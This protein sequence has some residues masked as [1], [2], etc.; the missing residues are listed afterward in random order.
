M[1]VQ[2]RLSAAEASLPDASSPDLSDGQKPAA[3]SALSRVWSWLGWGLALPG[4]AGVVLVPMD[5]SGQMMAMIAVIAA[6]WVLRT[7]PNDEPGSPLR[8]LVLLLTAIVSLRYIAWRGLFTLNS[9]TLIS[10]ALAVILYL[11]EVYSVVI[12]LLGALVNSTPLRRPSLMLA[13]LPPETALPTVDV[14]IP[15]YNEPAEMLEVTLRA[16]LQIQYPADLL[17]VY[18][19]DDGGTDAK[20]AQVDPE[21]AAAAQAR[22]TTLQALCHRLGARYLTRAENSHAKAGNI[23]SA[24]AH[25]DGDLIVILDADHVPTGD[26]LNR[27]VPWMVKR[28]DV[29]L[30]QTPHFMINPDPIDRNLLQS[31]RRMPSENDMFYQTIQ[32][33]LDF[34][35]SSFFCG[36]AAVLRRAPL[37]AIGGLA[38]QT[39]TEDAETA[40]TLHGQGLK[41]VYLDRPMVAGLNPE[42]FTAF[43]IQ[44]MRWAQG[45]TQILLLKRPFM[46]PGLSWFQRVGYMSSLLF[47]LFPFARMIF[48]FSPL[49]YLIGGFD[50]YN[51]STMQILAYTVPHVLA[52]YIMSDM[53]FGRT[54]WPLISEI[55]ELMQSI[56]SLNA[57]IKVVANPRHPSFVVTPKGDTMA[58]EFISPL[59]KPFYGLFVLV[60]IGFIFGGW[61]LWDDPVTRDM[62]MVVLV[63]NT[64][65]FLTLTAA[66]G[67][68][69]ERRQRRASPRMPAQQ[70]GTVLTGAGVSCDIDDLSAGG[71]RLLIDP[72]APQIPRKGDLIRLAA[73]APQAGR[74]VMLSC[75]VC[76]VFPLRRRLALGVRFVPAT[77]AEANDAVVLAFGDSARWQF[78]LDRR[79]RPIAFTTA[80]SMIFG[81]IWQPVLLHARMLRAAIRLPSCLQTRQGS[82]HE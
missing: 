36:S 45:M 81:L 46:A 53:L 30:V 20:I 21:N 12:S 38:G 35:D 37:M 71:A 75:E 76:S 64:L 49:A 51:A 25:T 60:G 67:A 28:P 13:D 23:N 77:E 59:A 50:V 79:V 58:E 82:T 6:L 14:L 42:T 18:L 62:T 15:T 8:L 73:P 48:I 1:T 78:F 65:N 68:L 44:R 4:L 3:P 22:R 66:L 70:T 7:L 19:L 80:L 11:A 26:F 17:R 9:S 52:G 43:V 41:S 16:A 29:F 56:F 61:R 40:I 34:W 57:L 32:K 39:I 72:S 10:T 33:G 2:T 47:W 55:Y 5:W 31:F 69:V 27:T 63:W 54:R 24:L 74:T